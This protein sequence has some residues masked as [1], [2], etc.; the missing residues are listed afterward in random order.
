MQ[1]TEVLGLKKPDTKDFYDVNVQNDNS[2]TLDALFKKD[3]NGSVVAKNASKL[4][5]HDAEY[6][7]PLERFDN[8]KTLN[9]DILA[10]ALTLSNGIYHYRL[11]GGNYPTGTGLPSENYRY[12]TDAEILYRSADTITVIIWGM[13]ELLPIINN[14]NGTKWSGWKELFTTAGGTVK[15][16]KSTLLTLENTSSA[17]CY[18]EFRGSNGKNGSLGFMGVDTPVML[19]ASGGVKDILHT[20]NMASHVLP[21]SGGTVENANRRVMSVSNS[22]G[23]DVSIGYRNGSTLLGEIGVNSNGAYYIDS[24]NKVNTL[25]NTGNKPTGTYTGNGD[26]TERKISTGGIGN[27]AYLAGSGYG[28]F[29]TQMGGI[30][31]A[32]DG[33][34]VS[35]LPNSEINFAS[36]VLTIKSA[37]I[38]VN[39]S[40]KT[41]DY[42]VL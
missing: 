22:G 16:A 6:F 19:T 24:S 31:F 7:A 18:Q 30:V 35:T 1:T 36:G 38:V 8:T 27:V 39:A 40:G 2:D 11:G 21:L 17:G 12:S 20:G 34:A 32:Y 29:V 13:N 33:R 3:A 10:H 5:G 4:D 23:A 41:I 37:N 28:V 26:A 15:G 9:T 42:Q 25:L 14:Y